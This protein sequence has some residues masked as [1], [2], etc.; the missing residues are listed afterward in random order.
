MNLEGFETL[1]PGFLRRAVPGSKRKVG[2]EFSPN[3]L[4]VHQ[5]KAVL[6]LS[7]PRHEFAST[8]AIERCQE[9][10]GV[11]QLLYDDAQ[12]MKVL[13]IQFGEIGSALFD[14]LP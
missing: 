10:H 3:R 7:E 13:V 5:A 14:L 8:L 6:D 1:G 9:L 12:P 4:V 11:A 2:D